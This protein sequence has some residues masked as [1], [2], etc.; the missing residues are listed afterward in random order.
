VTLSFRHVDN[1]VRQAE[2]TGD[3]K[4]VADSV[5]H[6]IGIDGVATEVL[7]ADKASAVSRFQEDGARVA[8]VGDGVDD[9]PALATADV[10]VAIGAGTDVAIES[11][12]IVLVRSDP[13]DVVGTIELSRATYHK[14]DSQSRLGDCLQHCCHPGRGRTVGPLGSG[15]AHECGSSDHE[16][17]HHYCGRECAIAPPIEIAAHGP[18]LDLNPRLRG[19]RSTAL[20]VQINRRERRDSNFAASCARRPMP[21]TV[22]RTQHQPHG[23]FQNGISRPFEQSYRRV[24]AS[25]VHTCSLLSG[26]RLI[27]SWDFY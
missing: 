21:W 3:S 5:A 10:G 11:A 23:H 17:V 7:P 9:A 22:I 1:A 14:D 16:L 18:R 27:S 19:E 12:G 25:S 4:K 20:T 2:I 26:I 24:L 8:M 13:R 6:D 15:S